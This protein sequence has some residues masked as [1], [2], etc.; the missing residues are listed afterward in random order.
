MVLLR[1]WRKKL[2]PTVES[3]VTYASWMVIGMPV[4]FMLF[5]IVWSWL[6][7]YFVGWR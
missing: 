5:L 1:I 4:A 6:T 3:P 7:L 2:G